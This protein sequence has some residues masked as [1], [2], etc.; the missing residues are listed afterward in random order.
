MWLRRAVL[1]LAGLGACKEHAPPAPL[2][3]ASVLVVTLDTTRTDALGC[4]GGPADATPTL[5]ALAREGVRFTQARTTSPVTLPAHATLMTG[6]FPFEHGVRDN[7]TFRLP[8]EAVTLAEVFS[9]HGYGTGAVLGAVVLD[10]RHG[11]AQGFGSYSEVPR[12]RA[13]L[14]QREAQRDAR[15]VVDEALALLSGELAP[16]YFLWVHCFDPHWPHEPPPELLRRALRGAPAQAFADDVLERKRYQA[17]VS[18]MDA[19]L[20]RLLPAARARAGPAGLLTVVLADH[21]EGLGDHGEPTHALQLFDT[22]VRIPLLVHHPS[23]AGGREIDELVS[24]VDVAPTLCGLLGVPSVGSS[25]ADLGALLR[26]EAAA[27]SRRPLYVEACTPFYTNGWAPLF[28]LLD[29]DGR[30]LIDGPAPLFFDV[31]A[32]PRELRDLSALEAQRAAALRA[33]FAP[34]A[35]RTHP[36]TRIRLDATSARELAALGYVGPEGAS[37][38]GPDALSLLPGQRL[39]GRRDP[40]E[41]LPIQRHVAVALGELEAGDAQGA[42]ATMQQVVRLDPENP[43]YLSNAGEVFFAAGL[44]E[45]A[46]EVLRRS[47]GLREDASTRCSL[48]L[49]IARRGRPAEALE[50]LRAN[51]RLHPAHLSTQLALGETLL[52]NGDAPG[53]RVHLEAFL[54]GHRV[55]DPLRSRAQALA[56]RAAAAAR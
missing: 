43:L 33:G 31:R 7:G 10:A 13:E 14:G 47:L 19:E 53:A 8:D 3:G 26:G 36:S 50:L 24:L 32:D 22:T 46:E 5:D 29:A 40:R 4:Y 34:L 16:P 35:A 12:Q 27:L 56:E 25:G 9:E 51:A 20:A 39:E 6:L 11:L 55:Q 23:L 42:A 37:D 49:V 44:V 41:G 54:A 48:A 21:G 17:E 52:A 30:K 38:D 28:G 2:A 18:F 15:E 45:L 1:C